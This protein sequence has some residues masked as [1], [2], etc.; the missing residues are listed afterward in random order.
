MYAP[1]CLQDLWYLKYYM[2]KN[3]FLVDDSSILITIFIK[4][5]PYSDFLLENTSL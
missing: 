2:F 4:D 3:Y 1:W 5:D